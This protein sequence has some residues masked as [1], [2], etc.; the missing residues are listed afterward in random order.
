MKRINKMAVK[1]KAKGKR[2]RRYRVWGEFPATERPVY[3]IA[4]NKADLLRSFSVTAQRKVRA[5]TIKVVYDGT[6]L[7]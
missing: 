6:T 5:G 4:K 2:K 1:R 7:F 3:Y